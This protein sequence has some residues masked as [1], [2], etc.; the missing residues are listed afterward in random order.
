MSDIYT[1][2]DS[3]NVEIYPSSNAK[4]SGKLVSEDNLHNTLVYAKIKDHTF[5]DE[6]YNVSYDSGNI[7]VTPGIACINGY[8]VST[9]ALV[10]LEVPSG[11]DPYDI[12]IKLTF[13][14]SK[15]IKGDNG[16]V[17]EGVSVELWTPGVE[18]S[19]NEYIFRI[20]TL[21]Y[22]GDGNPIVEQEPGLKYAYMA[23]DIGVLDAEDDNNIKSVQD[24]FDLL[25]GRYVSKLHDDT[26]YGNLEFIAD[27]SNDKIIIDNTKVSAKSQTNTRTFK[28]NKDEYSY[29]DTTVLST[30]YTSTDIAT[31][32]TGSLTEKSSGTA[33]YGNTNSYLKFTGSDINGYINNSL[34]LY[35]K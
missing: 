14:S 28:A 9:L 8:V 25:P 1:Y 19:P 34:Q 17:N 12:V 13:D 11:T 35:D 5:A 30:T 24:L 15:H 6:D 22:D 23:K 3:D 26:K 7:L 31:Q 18:P 27:G 21:T 20:G 2:Y 29:N 16:S 33:I 32:I 4:D 10:S